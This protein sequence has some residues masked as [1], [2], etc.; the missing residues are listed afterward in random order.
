MAGFKNLTLV[1]LYFR[2]K[3]STSN[4]SGILVYLSD[5]N[6][7]YFAY[8][9]NCMTENHCSCLIPLKDRVKCCKA[10]LKKF[11]HKSSKHVY[12]IL[13]RIYLRFNL[14]N[15]TQTTIDS[16]SISKLNFANKTCSNMLLQLF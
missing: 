1:I 8:A 12:D 10:M 15:P 3:Q 11:Y 14:T 2:M 9:F 7:F 5:L 16:L 6:A 13:T 4:D